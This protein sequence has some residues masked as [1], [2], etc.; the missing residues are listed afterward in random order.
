MVIYILNK[1]FQ[2]IPNEDY[3]KYFTNF[4][5]FWFPIGVYEKEEDALKFEKDYKA[6]VKEVYERFKETFDI[7]IEEYKKTYNLAK[8]SEELVKMDNWY[9]YN[10]LAPADFRI[11]EV[12]LNRKFLNK[13]F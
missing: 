2:T 3:T 8:R 5:A 6:R 9:A 1:T 4:N 10:Y 13:G 12:P 7:T 11:T